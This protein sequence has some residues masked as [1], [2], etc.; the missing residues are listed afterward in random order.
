MTPKLVGAF[1]VS[2]TAVGAVTA[3]HEQQKTEEYPVARTKALPPRAIAWRTGVLGAL[4]V[5]I[6]MSAQTVPALSQPQQKKQPEVQRGFVA[7]LPPDQ[8]TGINP[9][10]TRCVARPS[11]PPGYRTFCVNPVGASPSCCHQWRKC[12]AIIR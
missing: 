10:E 3:A 12:E 4:A 9:R 5:L 8:P 2:A 7:P 1:T 6:I 11:C